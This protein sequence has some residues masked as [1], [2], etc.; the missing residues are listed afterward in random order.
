MLE[1]VK[2]LKLDPVTLDG[3]A[4]QACFV[5]LTK[6]ENDEDVSGALEEEFKHTT[7]KDLSQLECDEFSK[8]KY[9]GTPLEL[10]I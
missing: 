2:K 1:K 6:K 7:V 4:A 10:A 3:E 9:G 8:K 5:N